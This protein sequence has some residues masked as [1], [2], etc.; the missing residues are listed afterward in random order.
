M[1]AEESEKERGK[2]KEA[3]IATPSL[4]P[5]LLFEA[6]FQQH[7]HAFLDGSGDLP[8]AVLQMGQ[9]GSSVHMP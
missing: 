6:R 7:L 3:V 1:C 4:G 5:H 9:E 8:A 2:E